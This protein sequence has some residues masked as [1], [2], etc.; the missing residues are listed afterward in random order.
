MLSQEYS[1]EL[2]AIINYLYIDVFS[3]DQPQEVDI[4]CQKDV[5]ARSKN[6][7][8]FFFGGGGGGGGGQGGGGGGRGGREESGS[9]GGGGYARTGP[10][11]TTAEEP[12]SRL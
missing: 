8:A 3:D 1:T 6:W 10:W 9:M 4:I 11:E 5:Y 12:G 2:V 7:E